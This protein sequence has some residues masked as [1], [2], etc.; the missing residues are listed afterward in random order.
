[1]RKI[2]KVKNAFNIIIGGNLLK[3]AEK[4]TMKHGYKGI[5]VISGEGVKGYYKKNGYFEEDTFM[6]KNFNILL[7]FWYILIYYIQ[8][9]FTYLGKFKIN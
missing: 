3:L 5:V 9:C 8:K 1:M 6:I 2:I 4:I 7:V